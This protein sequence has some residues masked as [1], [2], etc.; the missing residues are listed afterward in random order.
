MPQPTCPLELSIRVIAA[1]RHAAYAG[2]DGDIE[3]MVEALEGAV[4]LYE[5][6]PSHVHVA[7]DQ[8]DDVVVLIAPRDT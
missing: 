3:E 8:F 1:M 6:H 2:R 7:S 4:I 5:Q